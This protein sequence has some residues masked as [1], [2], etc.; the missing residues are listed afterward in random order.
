M[1]LDTI[2]QW[3][4]ENI[5]RS[6]NSYDRSR[7]ASNNVTDMAEVIDSLLSRRTWQ[8]FS[9]EQIAGLENYRLFLVRAKIKMDHYAELTEEERVQINQADESTL[10]KI[11]SRIW[12]NYLTN[13][14]DY[15]DG[16]AFRYLVFKNNILY[17]DGEIDYSQL[18]VFENDSHDL[19]VLSSDNLLEEYLSRVGFI[20]E[21][22][23]ESSDKIL[24]PSDLT[25]G[26]SLYIKGDLKPLALFEVTVGEK[27]VSG[28]YESMVRLA[29]ENN[30]LFLDLNKRNYHPNY[31]LSLGEKQHIIG[32]A[33]TW[34][35]L[36]NGMR[37]DID[38]KMELIKK[39]QSYVL[40]RF[41]YLNADLDFDDQAFL[42]EITEYINK[43]EN[44]TSLK[45]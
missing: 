41:N 26:K 22:D 40:K 45:L 3:L 8:R 42:K 35:M 6:L 5:N 37:M 20:V 29:D 32:H 25:N 21:I 27:M 4:K 38:K 33:I 34:Y 12:A 1:D 36:E 11:V 28:E 31:E 15:E 39:Y 16:K 30:V 10:R 2:A 19:T 7:I 9:D 43:R 23:W 18:P 24:L 17:F 13:P 44:I 14:F